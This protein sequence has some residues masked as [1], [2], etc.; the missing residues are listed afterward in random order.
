[1]HNYYGTS[2]M[3]DFFQIATEDIFFT[4]A[5]TIKQI[6]NEGSCVIVGR[7]ADYILRSYSGRRLRAYGA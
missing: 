1:M 5:R 7:Y 3:V 2:P 4:Q 6:A